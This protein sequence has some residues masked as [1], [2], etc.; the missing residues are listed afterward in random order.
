MH[1]SESHVAPRHFGLR[2]VRGDPIEVA[3]RT[4]IP[5]VRVASFA[6]GQATVGSRATGGGGG[7][8]AW[9]TPVAVL[10]STPAGEPVGERRIAVVDATASAL[11]GMATAAA[12]VALVCFVIRWLS[13][14]CRT[15]RAS[16]GDE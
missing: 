10:E 1:S 14:G 3:G 6:R 12:V 9:V 7:G 11:K 15:C 16:A 13:S 4:L 2:T 5:V 8:F